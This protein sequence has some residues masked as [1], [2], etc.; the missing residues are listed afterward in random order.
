MLGEQLWNT[1]TDVATN[2]SL[3]IISAIYSSIVNNGILIL[4]I[5]AIQNYNYCLPLPVDAEP[6]LV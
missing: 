3:E 5:H 2:L 4:A 6:I 1:T